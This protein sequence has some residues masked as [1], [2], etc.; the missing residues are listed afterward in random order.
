MNTKQ[1]L[2][3][4][5]NFYAYFHRKTTASGYPEIF[6]I[7]VTNYCPMNCLMCPR[8]YMR[9]S[10]GY[11][12]FELFKKIID[13]LKGYTN[14]V[15]LHH[16]GDPLMHPQ[17]DKFIDYAKAAGIKTQLSTNP[18]LLTIDNIKKLINLDYLHLSLDGS[19]ES[20]YKKL[21]GQNADY[22]KAVENINNLFLM[23]KRPY[24]VLAIIKMKETESEIEDFKKKWSNIVDEVEIKEFTTWDG[25]VEEI[26]E[27][28]SEEQLSIAY[29]EQPTYPC[30]RPWHRFTILWNG[31]VVP[32]CFDYA[33]KFILGDAK[34]QSL[35]EI[36]NSEKMQILRLQ[37]INNNLSNNELCKNCKEKLGMPQSKL[38]P[39]NPVF[40]KRSMKYL[41][42]KLK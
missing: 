23:K 2:N 42:Q 13:Q 15:W 16:F 18:V 22:K 33:G 37:H 38:Y 19:T 32:C 41:T 40:I 24:T 34:T 25:S 9:R 20:T 29:K 6:N 7:E 12:D 3:K 17:L 39:L 31:L 8:K 26:K 4:A 30:V 35:K 36:W 1:V 14:S 28:A 11:M 10:L 21:R 27:L 5:R